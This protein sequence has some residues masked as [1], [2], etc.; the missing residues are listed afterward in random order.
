[1]EPKIG[2]REDNLAAV[3]LSLSKILADEFVLYTKTK[4]AN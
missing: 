1:M 2:I 4:K 3:A